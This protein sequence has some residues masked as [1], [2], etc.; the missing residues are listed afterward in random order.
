[1]RFI[2]PASGRPL[3]VSRY[4]NP[5]QRPNVRFWRPIR[6]RRPGARAAVPPWPG[7]S[8]PAPTAVERHKVG[9][10]GGCSRATAYRAVADALAQGVLERA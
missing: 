5:C 8:A 1:M 9:G 3:G 4:T 7:D 2:P 10:A 6:G